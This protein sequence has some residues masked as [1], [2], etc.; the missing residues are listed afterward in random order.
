M[1]EILIIGASD[2]QF[3]LLL[4]ISYRAIAKARRDITLRQIFK[5]MV[6]IRSSI[7]FPLK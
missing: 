3:F 2:T 7:Q 4:K 1:F 6:S 5:F